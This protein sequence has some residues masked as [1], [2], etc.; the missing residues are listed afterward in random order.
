M[1]C[2]RNFCFHPSILEKHGVFRIHFHRFFK[3]LLGVLLQKYLVPLDDTGFKYPLIPVFLVLF[4]DFNIH[5]FSG[6]CNAY[7]HYFSTIGS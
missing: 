6:F 1:C 7:V 3:Y 4:T 2:Y 5:S